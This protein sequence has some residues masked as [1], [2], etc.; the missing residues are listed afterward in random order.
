MSVSLSFRIE[1]EVSPAMNQVIGMLD[2]Q[3]REDLV[4]VGARAAREGAVS[5][6]QGYDQGGGWFNRGLS[7]WQGARTRTHWPLD[8]AKAWGV[9]R[10]NSEGFSLVNAHNGYAQKVYGGTITARKRYLTIP[11]TGEAH[12]R[13]VA[14]YERRYGRL[15]RPR[16]RDFLARTVNGR[17]EVVY[18]LRKS[19]VQKPW[20][21]ALPP[22]G[23]YITPALIAIAETIADAL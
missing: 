17:L 6:H 4:R 5:Y 10:L 21:N 23:A 19:V 3:G 20:K 18:L 11:M 14:Q 13:S 15:F 1:D 22:E 9:G 2:G 7:T 16:G 8:L 12:G